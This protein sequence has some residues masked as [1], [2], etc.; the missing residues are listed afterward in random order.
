MT[1][2]VKREYVITRTG[3]P[4]GDRYRIVLTNSKQEAW[5]YGGIV[6]RNWEANAWTLRCARRKIRKHR[7]IG[8]VVHREPQ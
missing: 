3:L 5:A 4:W 2:D 8:T 1:D 6:W 7:L